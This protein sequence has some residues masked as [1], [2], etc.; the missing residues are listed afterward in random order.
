[1]S[2]RY[3]LRDPTPYTIDTLW[4]A[5][6]TFVPGYKVMK[7]VGSF[8][9]PATACKEALFQYYMDKEFGFPVDM[10]QGVLLESAY[11]DLI[12]HSMFKFT[13]AA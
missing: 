5:I 8:L 9:S 13:E 4:E 12:T 7:E 6:F 11:V 3:E 2:R 10:E 1:M